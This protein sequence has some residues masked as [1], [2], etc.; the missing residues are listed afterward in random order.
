MSGNCFKMMAKENGVWNEIGYEFI[1]V[2]AADDPIEIHYTIL[3]HFYMSEILH[4]KR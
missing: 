3:L 1:I 2:Q 4:K